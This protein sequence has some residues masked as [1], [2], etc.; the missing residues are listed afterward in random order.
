MSKKNKINQ[1]EDQLDYLEEKLCQ[2]TG[3]EEFDW[4]EYFFRI[5]AEADGVSQKELDQ[6]EMI[7][8]SFEALAKDMHDLVRANPALVNYIPDPK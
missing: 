5:Q 6:I 3:I 1:L 2:L 8:E 7:V 4:S